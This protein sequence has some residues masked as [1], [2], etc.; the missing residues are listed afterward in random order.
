MEELIATITDS[1]T[2]LARKYKNDFIDKINEKSVNYYPGN[3]QQGYNFKRRF[4]SARKIPAS[5]IKKDDEGGYIVLSSDFKRRFWKDNRTRYHYLVYKNRF[6]MYICTCTDFAF[7]T[8]RY[9]KHIIRVILFENGWN[10]DDD[11]RLSR[12]VALVFEDK[13]KTLQSIISYS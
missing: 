7:Q 3:D 5:F 9:C 10:N 8:P 13:D 12:R 4:K 6:N 1:P 2:T 11:S